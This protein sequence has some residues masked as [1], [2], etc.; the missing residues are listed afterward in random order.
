LMIRATLG[1]RHLPIT[2]RC[3]SCSEL[4]RLPV[5]SPVPMRGPGGWMELH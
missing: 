2:V 5:R 1:D 3:Q 4:G